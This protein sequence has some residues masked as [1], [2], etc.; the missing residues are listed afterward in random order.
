MAAKVTAIGS[1]EY[2]TPAA[3]PKNSLLDCRTLQRDYD[4]H[5]RWMIID[6]ILDIK[7][8]MGRTLLQLLGIVLG[9]GSIVLMCID[10]SQPRSRM[11]V[12]FSI[13]AVARTVK[14]PW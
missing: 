1:Q 3:R 14:R 10:S 2:P 12:A 7:D 11:S 4:R 5:R 9:A 13:A 6:G 8:H